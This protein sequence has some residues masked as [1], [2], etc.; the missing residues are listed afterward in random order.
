MYRIYHDSRYLAKS[1]A[2]FKWER[3]TLFDKTS[4][5]IRD[6]INTHGRFG[7]T[8]FTYNQGTFI[9]AANFLGHKKEARQAADFTKN[10]LC[11][12]GIL[13]SYGREGD[14]AGFNGIF[15]R[16]LARFMNDHRLQRD[17]Q[18]WLQANANAAWKCRRQSDDLSWSS[19]SEPTP[20]GPLNSW[21]CSSSV[22]IM[23]VV[24]PVDENSR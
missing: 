16:W 18:G 6:N 2:I 13:P 7:F 23:Q 12:D 15:A 3:D 21:A 4:G 10:E 19:W 11:Q 14:A 20:E 8:A 17:Y 5:R 1:K 9:G 22:V 24:P